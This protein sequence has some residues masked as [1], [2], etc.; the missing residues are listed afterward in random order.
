MRKMVFG[1]IIGF[2]MAFT[3][4]SFASN[5]NLFTAQRANFEILVNGEKFNGENPPLVVDGRTYLPL[6]DTGKALGVPVNWNEA[7]RRVEIGEMPEEIIDIT[8]QEAQPEEFVQVY[9]D[10]NI[11]LELLNY[12]VADKEEFP[13]IY[14]D[15][16]DPIVL[17]IRVTNKTNST[18]RLNINDF[19]G[20]SSIKEPLNNDN[21]QFQYVRNRIASNKGSRVFN[22]PVE[23]PGFW[24]SNQLLTFK[25]DPLQPGEIREGNIVFASVAFSYEWFGFQYKGIQL[26]MK[27]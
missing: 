15:T 2:V 3:L 6:R 19:R 14:S 22:Y 25:F 23:D 26:K 10:D 18:I 4:Q 7:K 11:K 1:F 16:S 27:V 9:E 20:L 13:Q 24:K 5:S 17:N 21:G 8:P 12:R